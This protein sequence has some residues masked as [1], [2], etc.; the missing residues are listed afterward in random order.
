[1]TLIKT[2]P[3]RAS[4]A[5]PCKLLPVAFGGRHIIA[6]AQSVLRQLIANQDCDS[7]P[8]GLQGVSQAALP[9]LRMAPMSEVLGCPEARAVGNLSV[10]LK[11]HGSAAFHQRHSSESPRNP[12]RLLLQLSVGW[13]ASASSAA[14]WVAPVSTGPQL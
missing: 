8:A 13:P 7:Q 12:M 4:D 2:R 3:L 11:P 1:V 10:L 6:Y 14:F 9:L 5:A